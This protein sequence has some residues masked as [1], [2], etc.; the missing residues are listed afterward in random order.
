MEN[1][2]LHKAVS[3][4]VNRIFG[5]HPHR[6]GLDPGSTVPVVTITY[7]DFLSP[8]TLHH[9]LTSAGNLPVEWNIERTMSLSMRHRLLEELYQQPEALADNP[10]YRGNVRYYLFDRFVSSDFDSSDKLI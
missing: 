1:I 5:H 10:Q 3:R 6:V 8:Q 7:Q 9:M 2:A 4:V